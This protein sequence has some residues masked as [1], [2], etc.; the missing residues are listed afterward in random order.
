MKPFMIIGA[1]SAIAEET[2]HALARDG[3]EHFV[4]V[5]RNQEKLSA[6][7]TNLALRCAVT[8]ETEVLD[9]TNFAEHRHF[10]ERVWQKHG[11]LSGVLIAHSILGEQARFE[12]SFE[13][14]YE[15]YQINTLSPISLLT[16]LAN[17]FYDQG[18]GRIVVI[19]SVA[20]DRG[21]ASNY[22][23]GSTKAALAAFVSGLRARLHKRGVLVTDVRPG[24][25]ISPMTSQIKRGAL[26]VSAQVAGAAIV[27]ALNADRGVVYV[28][29]FWWAIMLVIRNLP[30][31]VFRRLKI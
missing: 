25:I 6:V 12:R 19:T 20:V 24:F 8:A 5:G 11:G 14:V 30:D 9:F 21:R 1:T 10:I 29:W 15:A 28:P 16:H 4:L 17:L 3:Y 26:F 13:S 2:A 23:Y 7:A 22:V 27:R 18:Y 31:F